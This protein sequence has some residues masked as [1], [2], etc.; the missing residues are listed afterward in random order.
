M[1]PIK[2]LEIIEK[3]ITHVTSDFDSL[4]K[5]AEG[6][7]DDAVARIAK[8]EGCD[9]A[10]AHYLATQDPIAKRAYAHVVDLQ[11]KEKTARDGASRLAAYLR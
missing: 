7:Y 10:Q 3:S 2:Q 1:D 4:R 5:A 6:I 8:C 9:M 11:E